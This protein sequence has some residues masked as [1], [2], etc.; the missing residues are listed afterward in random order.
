MNIYFYAHLTKLLKYTPQVLLLETLRIH[1][2]SI[3]FRIIYQLKSQKILFQRDST[4]NGNKVVQRNKLDTPP[5]KKINSKI[6]H[7]QS[8]MILKALVHIS[9]SLSLNSPK[10]TLHGTCLHFTPR[11]TAW[12][13]IKDF[14][15]LQNHNGL[16]IKWALLFSYFS[17]VIPQHE[18][19]VYL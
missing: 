18:S 7:H 12:N 4:N 16:I 1:A 11:G 15:Y 6:K 3:I 10:P 17:A 14:L 13:T 9:T 2:I 19:A 8:G 5:P